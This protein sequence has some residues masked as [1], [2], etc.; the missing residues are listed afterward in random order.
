MSTKLKKLCR[1]V[2][3]L[4]LGLA[5][6]LGAAAPA[7]AAAKHKPRHAHHHAVKA[8]PPCKNPLHRLGAHPASRLYRNSPL[9]TAAKLK[10]AFAE[11]SFQKIVQRVFD[12]AK[13]EQ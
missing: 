11:K 1:A 8:K 4:G 5:L 7:G 9:S 10:K 2:C 12:Q 6:I 13:H 3:P